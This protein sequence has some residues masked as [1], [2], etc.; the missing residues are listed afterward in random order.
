MDDVYFLKG[1]QIYLRPLE[2]EDING[3]YLSWVNDQEITKYLDVGLFPTNK[4]DLK[5]FIMD[6][7]Q[8]RFNFAICTTAEKLHIGNCSYAEINWIHRIAEIGIMI[9]NKDYWGRNIALETYSLLVDYAFQKLALRKVNAGVVLENIAMIITLKKLGFQTEGRFR[10]HRFYVG[11][12][13]DIM[14][15]SLFREEFIPFSLDE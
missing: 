1:K 12:Y 14:R 9:G 7:N 4:E 5:S 2:V 10:K 6:K 11:K 8:I 15:F 3:P 13:V